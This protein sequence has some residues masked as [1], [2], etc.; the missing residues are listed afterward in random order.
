MR[1]TAGCKDQ[2]RTGTALGIDRYLAVT[3]G[4]SAQWRTPALCELQ[5]NV[6]ELERALPQMGLGE[7]RTSP[8][9]CLQI[10]KLVQTVLTHDGQRKPNAGFR[11]TIAQIAPRIASDFQKDIRSRDVAA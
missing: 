6:S 10:Q 2:H 8:K 7:A 1:L 3:A 5:Q 9:L 4:C 11:R